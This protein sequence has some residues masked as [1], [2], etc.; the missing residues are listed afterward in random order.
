MHIKGNVKKEQTLTKK[1]S[2]KNVGL[3]SHY[4]EKKKDENKAL[5]K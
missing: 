5:Q 2:K 4:N 1:E 3:K